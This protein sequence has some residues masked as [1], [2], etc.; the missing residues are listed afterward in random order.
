MSP[1]LVSDRRTLYDLK[2]EI[3]ARKP[4]VPTTE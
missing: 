3:D 4:K 1:P 2:L